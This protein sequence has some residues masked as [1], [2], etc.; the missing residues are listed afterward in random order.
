[1]NIKIFFQNKYFRRRTYMNFSIHVCLLLA[2][3]SSPH[4]LKLLIAYKLILFFSNFPFTIIN[5]ENGRRW[6]ND[7]EEEETKMKVGIKSRIGIFNIFFKKV[8]QEYYIVGSVGR[9]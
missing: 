4:G 1:M 8:K 7:Y 5:T 9:K 3:S 2:I 6:H